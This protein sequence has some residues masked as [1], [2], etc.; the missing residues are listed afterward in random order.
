MGLGVSYGTVAGAAVGVVGILGVLG[1]VGR[2]MGWWETK[3]GKGESGESGVELLRSEQRTEDLAVG[4][5]EENAKSRN[6]SDCLLEQHERD[7]EAEVV[8]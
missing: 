7:L 1:A 4:A 6:A 8:L 3:K 5:G 2:R